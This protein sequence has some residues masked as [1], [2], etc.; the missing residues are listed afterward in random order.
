M[1]DNT[2]ITSSTIDNLT[3]AISNLQRLS[4]KQLFI[5]DSSNQSINSLPII[6]DT[7]SPG[8]VAWTIKYPFT[9]STTSQAITVSFSNGPIFNDIP[10]L[11]FAVQMDNANFGVIPVITNISTTGATINLKVVSGQPD[12]TNQVLGN[13]HVTAI[14]Y[15]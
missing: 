11:S 8:L 12:T 1:P 3:S 6:G 15:H 7:T 4:L 14:G 2:I 9:I 10:T 5:S 13:L